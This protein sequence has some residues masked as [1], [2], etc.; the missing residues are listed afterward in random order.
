MGS[1]LSGVTCDLD[2]VR[3]WLR[4]RPDSTRRAYKP[5]AIEFIEGVGPLKGTDVERV[6]A[7]VEGLQGEPATRA[8]L[9]STI[10]SL[11]SWAWRTGY[12]E[13]NLGKTLRCVRVP[14]KL[15]TK[16]LSEEDVLALVRACPPGRD[17]ALLVLLY[18]SGLRISEAVSLTWGDLR[19]VHVSVTGKGTRSRTVLIPASVGDLLR[20]LSGGLQVDRHKAIFVS[21]T[22]G[23]P[24]GV[25]AAREAVYKASLRVGDRLP[26]HWLRHAHASHALDRGCPIHVVQQGLGQHDLQVPLREAGRRPEPVASVSGVG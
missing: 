14:S 15:H 8:R 1:D 22:T 16:L 3:Q 25:R 24:L 6:T 11:L 23:S 13:R 19:G 17:H 20:T 9:V 18:V 4:G 21:A 12:L 26:P 2:L 7:Y 5:V 10:K